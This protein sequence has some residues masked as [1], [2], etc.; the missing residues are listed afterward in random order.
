MCAAGAA[1]D[2]ADSAGLTPRQF[3]VLQ[4]LLLG[5]PNKV[6]ARELS[7]T[8]GTVKIHIAAI[9]RALHA[10]NRTEAVVRARALG[11]DNGTERPAR[12]APRPWR[13]P[14]PSAY[15]FF[16]AASVSMGDAA[17]DRAV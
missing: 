17:T 14:R 1:P 15:A 4:R 6:I 2:E 13:L 16:R 9:L 12:L 10:R 11:L 5:S 3:A 7:L 8:E